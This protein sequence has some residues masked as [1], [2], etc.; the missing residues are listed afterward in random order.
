MNKNVDIKFIITPYIGV[1]RIGKLNLKINK[2][3]LHVKEHNN[4]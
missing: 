3:K 1:G 4:S 2:S